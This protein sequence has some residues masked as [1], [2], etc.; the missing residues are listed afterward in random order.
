M[1]GVDHVVAR[2][3]REG[4]LRDVDATAGAPTSTLGI[5][6]RVKIGQRKDREVRLWHHGAGGQRNVD[7]SDASAGDG[8]NHGTDGA[9][10]QTAGVEGVRP[11]TRNGR[12]L[13][14]HGV[15]DIAPVLVRHYQRLFKGNVLVRKT[16][17]HGLAGTAVRN[18]EY[19][20]IAVADNLVDARDKAVVRTRQRGLLQLEFCGHGAAGADERHVVKTLLAAK[21]ELLGAHVQAIQLGNLRLAGT[22]LQVLIGAHAVIEQRAGL[23]QNHQR[24]VAHMRQRAIGALV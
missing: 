18:G 15:F 8:G 9:L 17:L 16:Q 1:R 19:H 6:A 24:I 12:Q 3:E 7:K 23:G 22:A 20:R 2:L 14:V 13:H 4:D 5:H 11:A 10:I 21:V